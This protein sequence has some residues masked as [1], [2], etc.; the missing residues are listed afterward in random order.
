M[1]TAVHS[2]TGAYDID[3]IHSSVQ[4]AVEHIV[5]TFRAS[6]DDIEGR[7]LVADGEGT[8]TASAVA[9]SISIAEPAEFREHV[10]NGDDFF[11]ARQHPRL[12]FHSTLIDL[13]DDG[14]ASVEGELTIRGVTRPLTA[15]GSYRTPTRDPFG[16]ERAA[17]HLRANVD[18]RIWGLSFQLPLPDGGD[19][20]GWDVELTANLELVRAA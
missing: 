6:F 10:L 15:E 8:L 1:S 7:L 17:L 13:R 9:T 14:T 5:S 19:A 4:F 20:V 16:T 2:L 18:R 12:T 3:P 11:Q